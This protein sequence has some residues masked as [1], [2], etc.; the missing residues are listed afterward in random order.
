MMLHCT[1]DDFIALV[2]HPFG[3]GTGH[4]VDGLGGSPGKHDF[5]GFRRT[6]E[7]P[8]TF[9]GCLVQ[10]GGL[11]RE[12][13]HATVYVGVHVQVFVAHGIE[14]AEGFL[15][16]GGIVEVDQLAVVYRPP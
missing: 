16:G 9:T 1:D 6:D 14:H 4:Q 3:K 15:R 11:L 7:L 2:H 8:H 10:V 13:V 12:V 5:L